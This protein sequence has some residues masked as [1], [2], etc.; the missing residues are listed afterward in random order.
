MYNNMKQQYFVDCRLC[1]RDFTLY[2][3]PED[4]IKW[5]NGKGDYIQDAFPYL[6]ADQRE[7]IMS[8][9]CGKCWDKMFEG[10]DE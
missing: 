1:H 3:D 8:N 5:D 4:F 9:T 2:I 7:L 6:E 10:W